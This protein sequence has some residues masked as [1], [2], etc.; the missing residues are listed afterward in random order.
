MMTDATIAPNKF[1][2]DSWDISTV[3]VGVTPKDLSNNPNSEMSMLAFGRGEQGI[4]DFT[5]DR[6]SVFG[7]LRVALFYDKA[8][9][10]ARM[11]FASCKCMSETD[12]LNH[13]DKFLPEFQQKAAAMARDFRI[14]IEQI[15]KEHDVII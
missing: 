11:L 1:L 10:A 12:K 7:F 3:V 13:K 4:V 2:V 5:C 15:N 9:Y 6:E 8:D 14:A